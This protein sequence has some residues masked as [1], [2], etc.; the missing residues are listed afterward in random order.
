MPMFGKSLFETLLEGL[1]EP[2][3]EEEDDLSVPVRGFNGG[4]VGRDWSAKPEIDVDPSLLFDGFPPDPVIIEPVIPTWI[5]RLSAAEIAED[6]A[7]R[8]CRTEQDLRD[9]RRQFALDNHPDRVPADYC[10][11]ATHRMKI[12]NQL[13]DAAL[14]RLR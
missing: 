5:G 1:G 4:F 7:L 6:L 9:R 8:D 3:E 11:Q 13:I 10:H 14:A 12:A 2:V